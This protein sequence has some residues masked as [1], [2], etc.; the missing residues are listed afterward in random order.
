MKR[1]PECWNFEEYCPCLP[2]AEPV[3]YLQD[4]WAHPRDGDWSQAGVISLDD[5][6]E[7]IKRF[8]DEPL[9]P[10]IDVVHPTEYAQRVWNVE[11]GLHP[12]QHTLDAY[13]AF[14]ANK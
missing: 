7:A 9:Q 1:C 12:Q 13:R 6:H 2:E 11:H 10:Y 4:V 5:L 3:D 14:W 8:H